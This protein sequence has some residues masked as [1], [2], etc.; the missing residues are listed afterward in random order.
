MCDWTKK[1][2]VQDLC[3]SSDGNW[4]VAVDDQLTIHLYNAITREPHFPIHLDSRP[5]SV[6][7]TGDSR[8][9]LVNKT[10][11]EAQLYDLITHEPVQVYAGHTGGECLIRSAVGGANESFV[12]SGS[13]GELFQFI[14]YWRDLDKS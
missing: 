3:G 1:H 14:I 2:R 13:E 4:L 10:D 11:G 9:L 7:I 8:F 12:L 5:T 6:N